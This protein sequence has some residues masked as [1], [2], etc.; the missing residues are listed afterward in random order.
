MARAMHGLPMRVEP[1]PA[2]VAPSLVVLH[3]RFP[4][5]ASVS[6]P[7]FSFGSCFS[8]GLRLWSMLQFWLWLSVLVPFSVLATFLR[9]L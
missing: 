7:C 8:S 2:A 4:F 6:V 1:A 9:S 5:H 3:T